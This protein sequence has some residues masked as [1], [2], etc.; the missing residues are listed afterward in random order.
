MRPRPPHSDAAHAVIT[1]VLVACTLGRRRQPELY[2][3]L[4]AGA[5]APA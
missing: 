1:A 5:Y 4:P 2:A 3:D